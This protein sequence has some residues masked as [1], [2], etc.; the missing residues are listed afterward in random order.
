MTTT[1]VTTINNT[2]TSTQ[3]VAANVRRSSLRLVINGSIQAYVLQ[4]SGTAS[5]TNRTFTLDEFSAPGVTVTGNEA[6]DAFQVIFASSGSGSVVATETITEALAGASETSI[7]GIIQQVCKRPLGIEPPDT[8]YSSSDRTA[9]ELAEVANA[10]ADM[11]TRAHRWRKLVQRATYSGDGTTVDYD[12]PDDYGFMPDDQQVWSSTA[13]IP[14][15]PMHSLD[16]W[17]AM[18]VRNFNPGTNA[19]IMYG[20]QIHFVPALDSGEVAQHFYQSTAS[21]QPASGTAKS[22]FTLDTDTFRID[23]ELLRKAI[24]YLWKEDKGLPYAEF[25]ND[26]EILKE[27]LIARDKGATIM[28][29]GRARWPKGANLAYP[30]TVPGGV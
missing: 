20:Q 21:V 9:Q 2:I 28:R 7:L 30:L 25:Q 10:A 13:Q 5:S 8:L 4:G 15:I 3:I 12:L 18:D 23:D 1:T 6:E 26:Y 24:I 16:D 14:L 17:L 29:Q 11:I 27:K 22:T 19:W